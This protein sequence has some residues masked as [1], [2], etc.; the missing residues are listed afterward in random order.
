M[1]NRLRNLFSPDS[2]GSLPAVPAGERIYAVG[3]VHGRLD[4]FEAISAAIEADDAARGAA[5]T[6]VILLGDLIDRGP[7]SAGVI[8]AARAWQQR[9]KVRI[10]LGNHEELLLKSFESDS[11]LRN[12]L[13]WGGRETVLSYVADP[14]EYHRAELA[15]TRLLMERS[16]PAADLNFIR[17][18]EDSIVAGDY[19]FVHAG[20]DPEKPLDA[21][22]VSDLRWIREP[23]LSYGGDLGAVVVHGH[24]ITDRPQVRQNRIGIDTGAYNSGSLTAIG[25][26]G[27]TRWFIEVTESDGII[28]AATRSMA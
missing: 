14:S 25:L 12:F 6:S 22:Q 17:S 23:F 2:R 28:T 3:D 5:T 10:L 11:V 24:T 15:D 13:R 4:L 18:F 7:E 16:I 8:A 1:F 19:L 20:V 27:S 21:Q 26:E 9:R